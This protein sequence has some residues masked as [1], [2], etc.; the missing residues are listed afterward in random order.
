MASSAPEQVDDGV[1]TPHHGIDD[2]YKLI[3]TLLYSSQKDPTFAQSDADEAKALIPTFCIGQERS[4]Q[5]CQ[6]KT[7]ETSESRRC[8]LSKLGG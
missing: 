3:I 7:A 1:E 5:N 4:T 6:K 2:P 8:V